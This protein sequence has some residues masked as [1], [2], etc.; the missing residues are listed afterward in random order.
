MSGW[1]G[2]TSTSNKPMKRCASRWMMNAGEGQV[3]SGGEPRSMAKLIEG[4]IIECI[5]RRGIKRHVLQP[6]GW[7]TKEE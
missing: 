5:E 4:E 1:A 3:G 2:L 6:K 7:I